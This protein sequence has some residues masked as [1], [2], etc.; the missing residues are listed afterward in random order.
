MPHLKKLQ[1]ITDTRLTLTLDMNRSD[2]QMAWDYAAGI[3]NGKL[4]S[5]HVPA[6]YGSTL[7]GDFSCKLPEFC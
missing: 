6:K 5:Q 1:F 4:N 3:L 7:T 2:A